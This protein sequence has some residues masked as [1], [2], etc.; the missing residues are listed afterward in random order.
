MS[1][2]MCLLKATEGK[3]FLLNYTVGI[4]IFKLYEEKVMVNVEE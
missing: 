2:N 1:T 4:F 3:A